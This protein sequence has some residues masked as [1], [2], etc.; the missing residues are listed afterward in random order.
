[1]Q[2]HFQHN[3]FASVFRWPWVHG[4][5]LPASSVVFLSFCSSHFCQEKNI[6]IWALWKYRGGN[7]MPHYS[8]P[9]ETIKRLLPSEVQ[10]SSALFER[11][12]G[13]PNQ[14]SSLE[15]AFVTKTHHAGPQAS[16]PDSTAIK[17]TS[18]QNAGCPPTLTHGLCFVILLEMAL[19]NAS[20]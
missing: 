17:V 2:I 14:A 12:W 20:L 3:N 13:G 15:Q 7:A 5:P 9:R 10:N 18:L 1:M 11:M 8:L 6:Y 4:W 16:Q 19:T